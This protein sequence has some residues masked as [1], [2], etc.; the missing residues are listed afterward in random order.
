MAAVM[1]YIQLFLCSFVGG[2]SYVPPSDVEQKI[3]ETMAE[4]FLN[5]DTDFIET[6]KNAE[7][8][9]FTNAMEF[10]RFLPLKHSDLKFL[11]PGYLDELTTILL[12]EETLGWY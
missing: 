1:F 10:N 3:L 7:F 5:T 2:N 12:N 9:P 4:K 8:F 11:F 6:K